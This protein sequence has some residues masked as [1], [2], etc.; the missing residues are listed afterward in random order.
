M[1]FS[2][3]IYTYRLE[4]RSRRKF[5][6]RVK[7]LLPAYNTIRFLPEHKVRNTVYH[8]YLAPLEDIAI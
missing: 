4:W 6:S 1:G 8:P 3:R 5:A 7:I 2:V